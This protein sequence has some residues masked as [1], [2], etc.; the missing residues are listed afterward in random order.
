MSVVYET[1]ALVVVGELS[2]VTLGPS[3]AC[4]DGF[5]GYKPA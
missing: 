3:G 5:G 2:Q 1:P 4:V